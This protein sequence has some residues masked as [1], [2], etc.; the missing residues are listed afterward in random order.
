MK[1]S[2]SVVR[3]YLSSLTEGRGASSPDTIDDW[4]TY[5][6]DMDAMIADAR[7]AGDEDLLRLAIDSLVADPEGRIDAFVGQVYAF[8]DEELSDLFSH[9]FAYIWPDEVMSEA[10][11][12][13]A[14]EFVPMSDEEWA[15]RR[16]G[17]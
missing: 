5:E 6:M 15:A 17:P 12:G 16:A 2:L 3:G 9:A 13:P 10:G 4:D 14:M 7:A 11:E 8:D 1:V